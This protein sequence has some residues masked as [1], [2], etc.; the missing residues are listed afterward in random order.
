MINAALTVIAVGE[1]L[2][3]ARYLHTAPLLYGR[4]HK[5]SQSQ[6]ITLLS[7]VVPLISVLTT[8]LTVMV[9][10]L[11]TKATVHDAQLN[12]PQ[13]IINTRLAALEVASQGQPGLPVVAPAAL[14][15]G[16]WEWKSEAPQT[17][18]QG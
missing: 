8:Y 12:G 5:M 1:G 11:S 2:L 4:N 3:G 16:H 13:G 9:S 14:P 6:I 15:G 10:K 18:H 17:T 7:V